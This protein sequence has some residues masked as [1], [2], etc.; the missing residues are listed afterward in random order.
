[1]KE[2]NIEPAYAKS[3][4]VANAKR[5]TC[6]VQ[7]KYHADDLSPNQSVACQQLLARIDFTRRVP[8]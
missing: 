8:S 1:M 4:G 3:F 2:K 5:P 7:R 6:N